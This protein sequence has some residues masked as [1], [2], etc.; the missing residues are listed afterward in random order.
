MKYANLSKIVA[1]EFCLAGIT[2]SNCV[3][4]PDLISSLKTSTSS[5]V[6][7]SPAQTPIQNASSSNET[8]S[9][10][11]NSAQDQPVKLKNVAVKRVQITSGDN[12]V[13]NQGDKVE[14][15]GSILY[16]DN[17]RDSALSWSSSDT[18][19]ATI[20]STTGFVSGVKPGVTT[21]IAASLK[22]SSKK[23]SATVTVKKAD[24]VEA[25]TRITPKEAVLFIGETIQLQASIQLSDGTVSPNVVW[26]SA[27]SSV[28]LVTNGLV[29]AIGKGTTTVTATAAGDS[30][31]SAAATI[32]V[33]EKTEE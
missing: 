32:I 1:I 28:A 10:A 30:T 33:E 2:L 26:K 5:D 19:I 3:V 6:A 20:N 21:I 23:A 29:T 17:S 4:S 8:S 31:K 7:T 14:L 11:T 22:D 27:N 9:S 25:L 18:T 24:V 12:I 16:E 15:A 13:I